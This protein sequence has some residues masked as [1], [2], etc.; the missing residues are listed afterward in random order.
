MKQA[1]LIIF[2]LAF[3]GILLT[4]GFTAKDPKSL[5]SSDQATELL[6][7]GPGTGDKS[8]QI[9]N[10][11]A[12]SPLPTVTGS[13]SPTPSVTPGPT[14][15]GTVGNTCKSKVAIDFLLDTS[16][17]MDIE[18]SALPGQKKI[19]FLKNAM[20]SFGSQL[21]SDT[22]IGI[23][24][25]SSPA[26]NYITNQYSV[27]YPNDVCEVLPIGMYNSSQYQQRISTLLG[28]GA[29]P[30]KDAF[31]FAKQTI[32][33]FKT[34]NAH[35]TDYQWFL[36]FLSDGKPVPAATQWP[37]TLPGG[38]NADVVTP[39]K[40]EPNTTI[41]SIGLGQPDI[42]YDQGLMMQIAS[43]PQYFHG[44]PTGQYLGSTFQQV[45]SQVCQ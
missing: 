25:F 41:I 20:N 16:A 28:Y 1:L 3:F 37:V 33:N 7:P 13:L 31:Q 32:D 30:M 23:Q 14:P 10:Q 34:N 22:L 4:G 17:S 6:T 21:S 43:T 38:R 2:V 26:G 5:L 29:T 19:D 27:C 8:L 45:F 15:T 11:I 36:V 12:A 40:N 39:I 35:Y 42:D 24:A 44:S 18:D 9:N